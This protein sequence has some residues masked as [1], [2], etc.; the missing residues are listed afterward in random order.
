VAYSY[1]NFP[2]PENKTVVLTENGYNNDIISGINMAF[3]SA[4]SQTRAMAQAFKGFNR[5]ASAFNVWS[6]VKGNIKYNRDPEGMQMIKLPSRLL[7][8]KEIG[9]DCKSFTLLCGSLLKNLGYPVTFRY[10]SYNSDPTPS[11]IYCITYDKDNS[12]IIVDAVYKKFNAELPYKHK[13]DYL[14]KLK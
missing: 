7:H 13:R 11:H 4:V 12:P 3:F 1:R 5:L 6:F 9:G 2:K 10:V 8:E 14:M